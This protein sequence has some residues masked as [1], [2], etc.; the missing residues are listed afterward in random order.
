MTE[1]L[2]V[3]RIAESIF[4]STIEV[5][6]IILNRKSVVDWRQSGKTPRHRRTHLFNPH[7]FKDMESAAVICAGF[8]KKGT[9]ELTAPPAFF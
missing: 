9:G 6:G 7:N 2:Y 5:A 3:Q 8:G 4:S 1:V